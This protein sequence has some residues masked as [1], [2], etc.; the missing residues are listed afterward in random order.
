MQQTLLATLLVSTNAVVP[1]EELILELWGMTPPAKVGNALQAQISRLRRNLASVEPERSESRVRTSISGYCLAIDRLELD[2]LSFADTVEMIRLRVRSG[3]SRSRDLRA[4]IQDLRDALEQW[5][6]PVFGGLTGGRL[7]QDAGI[8]FLEAR[9]AALALL[10]ELELDS[11]GHV[12]ILPELTMA[13]LRHPSHEQFC[14]LLMR[15][16]YLAERQIDALNVYR[17]FRGH[18]METLGIDPSPALR[19]L[20]RAILTHDPALRSGSLAGGNLSAHLPI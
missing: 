20:E 2:A 4:D 19:A 9:N 14:I 13:H 8:G 17:R 6:G 18:L 12:R 15:A 11:G 5:R 16:L 3:D 1:V 10:Y 7:C